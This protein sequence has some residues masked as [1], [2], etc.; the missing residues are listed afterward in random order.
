MNE[1]IELLKQLSS[2]LS[3][4]FEPQDWGIINSTPD[5]IE[6]FIQYFRS[7]NL[8]STLN[9]ELMDLI[10][11]SYNDAIVE[12]KTSDELQQLFLEFIR[13]NSNNILF[14]PI[15]SYWRSLK[16]DESFPVAQLLQ[17]RH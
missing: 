7:H 9:Y 6:E 17:A 14:D 10:I 5:R 15:I 16:D 4:S 3:L 13:E 1:K 2:A 12:G 8:D 11:A